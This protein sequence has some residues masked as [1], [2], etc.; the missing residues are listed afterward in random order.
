MLELRHRDQ[1]LHVDNKLRL[2]S[3]NLPIAFAGYLPAKKQWVHSP[4]PGFQTVSIII[5]GRGYL[6]A[7]GRVFDVVAPCVFTPG[8]LKDRSYGPRE[9][10]EEFYIVYDSAAIPGLHNAGVLRHDRPVWSLN[11]MT[12]ILSLISEACLLIDHV[13]QHGNLDRLD[14]VCEALLREAVLA[15]HEHP[16]GQDYKQIVKARSRLQ[17]TWR[18]SPDIRSLARHV[19]M[20]ERTFRRAWNRYF[21]LTPTQYVIALRVDE[22]CRLLTTTDRSIAAISAETGFSDSQYFARIF[23]KRTGMTPSVYRAQ[24]GQHVVFA[25]FA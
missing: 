16:K 11:S 12:R 6:Q 20:S 24:F 17:E 23:G 4:K 7:E 2:L 1:C 15:E 5:S 18:D 22:A 9:H 14:G 10:W 19:G 13:D 25:P 8:V 21:Q 3:P